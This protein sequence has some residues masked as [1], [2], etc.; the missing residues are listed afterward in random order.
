RRMI[1][2]VDRYA[3]HFDS[4]LNTF[5]VDNVVRDASGTPQLGKLV[6]HTP[7]NFSGK[8]WQYTAIQR[9]QIGINATTGSAQF[10]YIGAVGD[11]L[12]TRINTGL[13]VPAGTGLRETGGGEGGLVIFDSVTPAGDQVINQ[14]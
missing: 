1:E 11:T 2:L 8:T 9:F 3:A 13:D 6:W 14:V 4:T 7:Q 10:V 5:I 12:P